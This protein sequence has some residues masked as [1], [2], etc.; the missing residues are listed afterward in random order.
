M[1][2]SRESVSTRKPNSLSRREQ[3]TTLNAAERSRK[4]RPEKK[5]NDS[6]N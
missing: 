2:K 6:R 4:I 3:S 1:V 5:K